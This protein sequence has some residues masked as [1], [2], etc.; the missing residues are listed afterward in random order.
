MKIVIF[1]GRLGSRIW[2]VASS[3]VPKSFKPLLYGESS[4]ERSIRVLTQKYSIND[5]YVSSN[6]ETREY[7]YKLIPD[8]PRENLIIEPQPKDTGPALTYVMMRLLDR[9]GDEP[10][11]VNWTNSIVKNPPLYFECVDNACALIESKQTDMVY[12]SIPCK[13]PNHTVGYVKSGELVKKISDEISLYKFDSFIEK[14]DKQ[15]AQEYQKDADSYCW[16]TGYYVVTPRF[17]IDKLKNVNPV[18][19]SQMMRIHDAL[20]TPLEEQV[21]VDV[22]NE[23]EKKA[24]DYLL[25][26][27]LKGANVMIVKAD[28]GWYYISTWGQLKEALQEVIGENVTLGNVLLD[29]TKDSLVYNMDEGKLVCTLGCDNLVVLNTDKVTLV[30]NPEYS[31]DVKRLVEGLKANEELK[32]YV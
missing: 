26:E 17:V 14:L 9:F 20:G 15:K 24:I 18:L 31:A 12:L 5:I 23:V 27:R 10:V 28:Y 13:Y 19:F 1:A 30:L 8:F 3:G 2:P 22:F 25:W 32:W 21:V 11:L 16:D 6:E 7:I 29:S 4:L